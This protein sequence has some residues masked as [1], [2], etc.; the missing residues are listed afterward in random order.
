MGRGNLMAEA[1]DK[2]HF[3]R[4]KKIQVMLFINFFLA[5]K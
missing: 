4:I 3:G 1:K 5:K 2:K